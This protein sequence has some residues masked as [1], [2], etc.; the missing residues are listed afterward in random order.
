MRTTVVTIQ[1]EDEKEIEVQV[2]QRFGGK[3]GRSLVLGVKSMV[4]KCR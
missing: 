1:L 4:M 3:I 2:K